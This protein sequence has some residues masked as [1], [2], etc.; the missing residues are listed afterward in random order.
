MGRIVST[1]RVIT[2][3]LNSMS[4]CGVSRKT[5]DKFLASEVQFIF[6]DSPEKR[7]P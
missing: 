1:E 5:I 3:C 4:E 6:G 7:E 2:R